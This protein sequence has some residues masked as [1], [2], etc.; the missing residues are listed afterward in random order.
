M[1]NIKD[2]VEKLV[3]IGGKYQLCVKFRDELKRAKT[4]R[5]LVQIYLSGLDF[6]LGYN[7]PP[8][9][10]IENDFKGVREAMG[11]FVSEPVNV[12]NYRKVV[13][14]GDCYGTLTYD[15][16]EVAQIFVKH[17]SQ[18]TIIASDHANISVDCFDSSVV[19]IMASTGTKVTIFRYIGAT[20]HTSGDGI[21]KVLD[22]N[23]KSY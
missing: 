17:S 4:T 20:V 9:A 8:L 11:V 12:K 16:F 18:V 21:V 7:Y 2:L 1:E 19:N 13:M 22:R 6:C 14:L 23:T 3:R 5:D 15:D 10:C